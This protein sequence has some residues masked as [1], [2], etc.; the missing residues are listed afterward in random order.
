MPAVCRRGCARWWSSR[1]PSGQRLGAASPA[2]AAVPR[3][4]RLPRRRRADLPWPLASPGPHMKSITDTLSEFL[5]EQMSPAEVLG[6]E[7]TVYV[8]R[9]AGRTTMA[10]VA[11]IGPAGRQWDRNSFLNAAAGRCPQSEVALMHR[12]LDDVDKRGSRLSWGNGVTPGAAGWYPLA[13]QLTGVWALNANR[14]SPSARSYL[15]FYLADVARRLGAERL[16][17]AASILEAIPSLSEL[18]V[19]RRQ[20]LMQRLCWLPVRG[21]TGDCAGASAAARPWPPDARS[22]RLY[23]WSGSCRRS[24]PEVQLGVAVPEGRRPR[25]S[26][27]AARVRARRVGRRRRC[28]REAVARCIP[29]PRP[30]PV[31]R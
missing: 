1:S 10:A 28:A 25:R 29:K 27:P 30:S 17:R 6:V 3:P 22:G 18:R 19:Q 11:K 31:R 21:S 8:P 26:S 9:V 5:N 13:G 23:L 2:R 14:E 12:L 20:V 24:R 16:E 4:G 15:V 7:H